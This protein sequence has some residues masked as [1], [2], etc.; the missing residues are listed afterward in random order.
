MV[1]DGITIHSSD[2]HRLADRQTDGI[3]CT[4]IPFEIPQRD[5]SPDGSCGTPGPL[6]SG[7]LRRCRSGFGLRTAAAAKSVTRT[8]RY[9]VDSVIR[10]CSVH[11]GPLGEQVLGLVVIVAGDWRASIIWFGDRP[12][13]PQVSRVR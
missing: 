3:G 1:D 5:F 10:R 13:S 12:L 8:V 11:H 6:H 2:G 9:S 7:R 4:G